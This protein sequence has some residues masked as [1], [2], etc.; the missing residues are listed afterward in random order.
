MPADRIGTQLTHHPRIT[1]AL[2]TVLGVVIGAVLGWPLKAPT[3]AHRGPVQFT[4]YPVFH[5]TTYHN[6]FVSGRLPYVA[7]VGVLAAY[8]CVLLGAGLCYT[9]L[10]IHNRSTRLRPGRDVVDVV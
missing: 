2:G 7:S 1:I 8:L 9:A 6:A 3:P 5:E 4:P 10:K